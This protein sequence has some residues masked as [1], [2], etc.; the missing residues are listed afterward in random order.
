MKNLIKILLAFFIIVNSYNVNAQ[1]NKKTL[2]SGY[3]LDSNK[4]PVTNTVIFIDGAKQK[5]KIRSNGYYSIALKKAPK[6]LMFYSNTYGVLD[7]TYT[8]RK[9]INITFDI[10]KSKDNTDY[11]AIAKKRNPDNIRYR[12]IYEYL[13]GKVAGVYVKPDN[14]IVIRGITSLKG[15]N[16]P[17]FVVN[18]IALTNKDDIE[19]VNP[20][21]IKSV[22]VLKGAD[23]SQYGV[24]GAAGVV[25]ITTF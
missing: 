22:E 15:S 7:Y 20:N 13:R 3:V 21:D 18:K 23:A 19:S 14:T 10:P 9:K 16:E 12:N 8:G 5:I 24:R 1:R 17:L 11:I 2:I 25:V 4:K 6:K